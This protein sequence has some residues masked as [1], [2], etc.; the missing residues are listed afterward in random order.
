MKK[1]YM[2][3]PIFAKKS[4]AGGL[5]IAEDGL[6]FVNLSREGGGYRVTRYYEQP[7]EKGSIE[8]GEIKDEKKFLDALTNLKKRI[9]SEETDVTLTI[10]D[11]LIYITSLEI[12]RRL[13][14]QKL[15]AIVISHL[16][17]HSPIPI[18]E[19]YFDWEVFPKK[20][21]KGLFLFVAIAP[22]EKID[23]FFTIIPRAGF[24]ILAIE[25]HSLSLKRFLNFPQGPSLMIIF[26]PSGMHASIVTHGGTVLSFHHKI[27]FG[28]AIAGYKSL[29]IGAEVMKVVEFYLAEHPKEK[30]EGFILA[31]PDSVNNEFLSILTE[32]LAPIPR[33]ET[34]P[35]FKMMA[36]EE[37]GALTHFI[38]C[39]GAW[40]GTVERAKD[41]FVSLAPI[42]TEDLWR[43]ARTMA[44][45]R[46]VSDF[47]I[48]IGIVFAL[49]FGG[50]WTYLKFYLSKNYERQLQVEKSA[51]VIQDLAALNTKITAYNDLIYTIN[52]I[53][54]G[55]PDWTLVIGD[56]TSRMRPGV[57]LSSLSM[58]ISSGGIN[59]TGEAETIGDLV[60]FRNTLAF[61]GIA[62]GDLK[63][64]LSSFEK[65]AGVPFSFI[66]TL[67]NTPDLFPYQFAATSTPPLLPPQ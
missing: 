36:G 53:Y 39:A 23:T 59:L 24:N 9:G 54:A 66:L 60:D 43:Q 10:P 56:I 16:G 7:L 3:L 51:K 13:G 58:D 34:K 15:E 62:S 42:G 20:D 22:K 29:G 33:I 4:N 55:V 31:N 11:D 47:V 19:S 57:T 35:K 65:E 6:T 50:S 21:G 12:P 38:A 44:F 26:S 61:S 40:R 14:P 17:M 64:P 27:T 45:V 32:A 8:E 18:E 2:R 63:I 46:I 30:I 52:Q 48:I 49:I 67:K 28:D 5:T 25:T 1:K 37:G 41:T